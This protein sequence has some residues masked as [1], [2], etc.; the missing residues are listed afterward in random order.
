[1]LSR[2]LFL[3]PQLPHP[4]HQGAAI[5]NLNLVKI[6]ARQHDVVI[7]SFVRS[8]EET[9]AVEVLRE[10]ACEVRTFPAPRRSL[11][12]RALQTALSATPDMGRRLHS[13]DFLRA[14]AQAEA[15]IVQAEGIEMAQYLPFN[16]GRKVFDCHNAE[17]VLQRRTFALDAARGRLPGAAY[18]F[19]QWQKLRRYERQACQQAD[20]VI[21]V[22]DEDRQALLDLDP[23]LCVDIIPNGVDAGFFAPA[24][25]PPR[26]HAFLFTGTLDFRPNIDAVHWLASDIWPR[27]RRNLPDATLTLAGRAPVASIRRL[28]GCDG[29]TVAPSPPDI[30]PYFAQAAVY[31]VPVRAGGGS[32]YKLLQAMSMRMG[33]VST[34]LGAEG[35]DVVDGGQVRLADEPGEF[36][37]AAVEL[38]RDAGQRCRLGTAARELVLARY[39]WP[40]IAP[41]LLAVYERLTAPPSSLSALQPVS[42]VVTVLNEASSVRRLLDELLAQDLPPD[43]ILVVDGGSSDGTQEVVARYGPPVRLIELPGAN[44][45]QG[46]NRG[47]D[48]ART[49]LIAVTDA[50]VRLKPDWLRR[51]TAPLQRGQAEV[52]AGFFEPDPRS[53]FEMAMGAT[54][55]PAL[56]DLDPARFLPS[57]RSIAFRKEIWRRVGGYPEWLDYCEDLILDINVR[58]LKEVR[59]VFAPG[60]T[61]GF[62]PRS[63]L[64]A[65]FRQYFRYARGDGKADL[66]PKRHAARYAAYAYLM[67]VIACLA[68]PGARRHWRTVAALCVSVLGGA[69]LYLRKPVGRLRRLAPASSAPEWLYM[70]ALL[71]VIRCVGDVA[72]MLGYPAGV[73]WRLKNKPHDWRI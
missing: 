65:F 58:R 33:I 10:W 39:D 7:Y 4:P 48:E 61:A 28:H 23:G 18:S 68:S 70:L 22:S 11:A 17:W 25:M 3:T 19:A 59:Q 36:A 55:L 38:V 13:S 20:A 49:E 41:G 46:R 26:D 43:E 53:L 67:A 66:W 54:V 1:V 9:S 8:R 24:E 72:K 73:I 71:P 15:D 34:R 2:I 63:S 6:A 40:V 57:S 51:I 45:S 12:Q 21:A 50:G 69:A 44:I 27:I 60:A 64:A 14:V 35:I 62:R 16:S 30:R 56:D 31:L 29:I 42:V 52:V 47:I 32:R 5:R 37:R